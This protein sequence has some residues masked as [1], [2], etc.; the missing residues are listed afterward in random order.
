MEILLLRQ[1][2]EGPFLRLDG[3][4]RIPRQ[5]LG[6]SERIKENP[7][8]AVALFSQRGAGAFRET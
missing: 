3:L 6:Q 7:A 8:S 5:M 1:E 2:H 4:F